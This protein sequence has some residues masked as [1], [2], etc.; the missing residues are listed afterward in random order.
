MYIVFC[1]GKEKSFIAKELHPGTLY[2]FRYILCFFLFNAIQG[3][4]VRR[5]KTTPQL[6]SLL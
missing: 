2:T 3:W 4:G 1:S 6:L 5:K